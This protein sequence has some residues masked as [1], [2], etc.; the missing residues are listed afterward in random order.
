M[1]VF[2]IASWVPFRAPTLHDAT[3]I[4][5]AMVAGAW[6]AP[7]PEVLLTL[8]PWTTVAVAIGVLVF[9]G[10]RART[11]LAMLHGERQTFRYPVAMVT[12]PLLLTVAVVSV[13]WL[14]F[15][16]FLYFQF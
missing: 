9:L 11:G 8:T 16:P 10:P 1:A 2:I 5:R 13:L 12:A 7:S 14:D 15:S 4:W 6:A 3:T